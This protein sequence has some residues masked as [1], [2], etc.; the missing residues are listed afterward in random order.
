MTGKRVYIPLGTTA[1]KQGRVA[2]ANVAGMSCTFAGVVGTAVAKIFDLEV[3]RTGLTE[4]EA[5]A[6]GWDVQSQVVQVSDRA[7]YY[8]GGSPLH[9]KLI[10]DKATG[11][12]LG[13]QM[14][15]KQG[16]SKRIDVLAAALYAKMTIEDLARLDCS[17]APPYAPVWDPV[18]VA[19]NAVRKC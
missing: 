9:V 6:N 7:R 17:Y 5:V 15:G 13:A 1:N 11:R 16:A 4:K 2:G 14:V 10:V 19:A 12:L 18:L 8:P 3:A